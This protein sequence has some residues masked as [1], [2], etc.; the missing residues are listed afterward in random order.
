M[1]R[2][3][4]T[5]PTSHLSINTDKPAPVGKKTTSDEKYTKLTQIEHILKRPV[6]HIGSVETL[7]YT[8]WTHDSRGQSN[9]QSSESPRPPPPSRSPR[10]PTPTSSSPR[11]CLRCSRS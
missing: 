1:S 8:M 6:S 4:A 10:A 3:G 11:C 7:T 2:I 9:L 5:T